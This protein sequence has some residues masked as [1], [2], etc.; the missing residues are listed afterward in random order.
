MIQAFL[1][2]AARPYAV[3][4]LAA[5]G[6]GSDAVLLQGTNWHSDNHHDDLSSTRSTPPLVLGPEPQFVN[7]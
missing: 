2:G 5:D 6:H 1:A 4:D 7:T 3:A